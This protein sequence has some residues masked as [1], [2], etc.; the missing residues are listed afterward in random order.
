MESP[1]SDGNVCATLH[2]PYAQ[3]SRAC[4]VQLLRTRG[5]VSSELSTPQRFSESRCPLG[6]CSPPG[7]ELGR[8]VASCGRGRVQCG[9]VAF[10][11]PQGLFLTCSPLLPPS[12]TPRL[13]AVIFH[14]PLPP[15][16]YSPRSS[17]QEPGMLPLP[18]QPEVCSGAFRD[19][20]A[21]HLPHV[22]AWQEPLS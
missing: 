11:A 13:Q 19:A 10:P 17:N 15:Q 8:D 3:E 7:E 16:H 20:T 9:G 14:S 21:P 2:C 12:H 6:N 22:T 1:S 4:L 5:W 18:R